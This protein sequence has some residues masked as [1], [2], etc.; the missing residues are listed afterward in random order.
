MVIMYELQ[1]NGDIRP[2]MNDE[3]EECVLQGSSVAAAVSSRRVHL[4][5][6]DWRRFLADRDRDRTALPDSP[7]LA[8]W[9]RCLDQGVDPMMANCTA[10]VPLAQIEEQV[11]LLKDLGHEVERTV[12]EAIRHRDLLMTVSDAKGRLLRTIGNKRIL[13]QADS[14]RFGPGAVWA[15]GSVGTNAISLA[16]DTKMPWQIC[17]VEH[18]C[19]SHHAWTCSATPIFTP[20]GSLWGCLDISG[21]VS[22][23]HSQALW[24]TMMAVRETERLL[25]NAS[26]DSMGELS[27]DMF[28]AIVGSVPVG[29][30]L[31]NDQGRITFANPL[32][33]HLLGT[34]S[35]LR[36]ARAGDHFD[37]T[38]I[39]L[40]AENGQRALVCPARPD[41]F[42]EL[43][44]FV[45][46]NHRRHYLIAL[47]CERP[48]P[49]LFV[50]PGTG[51]DA[52]QGAG[53]ISGQM[54]GQTGRKAGKPGQGGRAADADD[55]FAEI[56][57]RSTVMQAVVERART[58]AASFAPILLLG[59]T[60]TGKEL[61]ARA[62]HK[63]GAR[64]DQPFVAVNC[65]AL[66]REL[67]QSELFGYEK[68]SFTGA[69]KSTRGKFEQAHGGTLF[70]DE[71]SEMPLDMQVNLLRPLE[72]GTV[73][74]V[75]GS[76]SIVTDF[77][78]ITATNRNLEDL[79]AR[80]LFR[81]DLFYRIHVLT[82]ELPPLRE[83]TG[84]VTLI[85]RTY[86]QKL[87]RKHNL[88]YAG[89][90]QA[91]LS[92]LEAYD[93]PGNVRQLVHSIEYAVNMAMGSCIE[94]EHLPKA[95]WGQ[96]EAARARASGSTGSIGSP[97]SSEPADFSLD[98][99]ERR[100]IMAAL[101]HYGGNILKAARALGIGRNTLY[102]KMRKYN[103]S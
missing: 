88:P 97:G 6:E 76:Q 56:L 73:T 46:T 68:G 34:S 57:C 7:I 2:I 28:R 79:I 84:D 75:G 5:I 22:S 13:Q 60:G 32:A 25:F 69:G 54:S 80:K 67:I 10:F 103:I 59:E 102:A 86:G 53:P 95:L 39:D 4:T 40:A 93:W 21:H 18:F 78:L 83:R 96:Q 9:Q 70:L 98:N 11:A 16:L 62:L 55:P 24:L 66:P 36:G 43:A 65:G 74:R 29:L 37:L 51:A 17:G 77:R 26:L 72:T 99:M 27:R 50:L 61:F 81:E 3:Q 90:S 14:L 1:H 87:A 38:G 82:L 85:A 49:G 31:V 8:S 63:A 91:A 44:P 23:N 35:A 12:Y 42:A 33:E 89:F 94:M 30:C 101:E 48:H 58:M 15:E 20:L 41:L 52:G 19:I 71:I 45:S 64:A 100:T 92:C 47:H